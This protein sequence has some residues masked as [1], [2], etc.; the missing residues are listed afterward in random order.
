MLSV[1]L[2]TKCNLN[3]IRD[4]AN[5]FWKQMKC[6]TQN[7]VCSAGGS[8]S[9]DHL[10]ACGHCCLVWCQFFKCRVLLSRFT[11]QAAGLMIDLPGWFQA[12]MKVLLFKGWCFGSILPYCGNILLVVHLAANWT[13]SD[14]RPENSETVGKFIF[15][16]LIST[17]SQ[18]T[19]FSWFLTWDSVICVWHIMSWHWKRNLSPFSES[20]WVICLLLTLFYPQMFPA[21]LLRIGSS[22]SEI[23]Y[24]CM[25]GFTFPCN[26]KAREISESFPPYWHKNGITS[27]AQGGTCFIW[28]FKTQANASYAVLLI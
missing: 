4:E 13:Y 14:A 23:R 11:L 12:V 15:W 5:G 21:S 27:S 2:L 26:E 7:C 25:T 3:F 28:Y 18:K 22:S 16:V 10:K 20:A 6:S 24:D 17:S 8:L 9:S 1:L 19:S